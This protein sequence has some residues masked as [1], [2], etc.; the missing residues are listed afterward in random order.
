MALVRDPFFWKRFSTAVHMDEEAK[1]VDQG[2]QTTP[3]PTS[4]LSRERR[5]RK[6]SIIYGFIIFF[7]VV[8]AVV[9]SVIVWWLAKNNWLQPGPDE[10]P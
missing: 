4:W 10:T 6:R 3:A 9:A 2:T 1:A 5:K 8:F 7:A